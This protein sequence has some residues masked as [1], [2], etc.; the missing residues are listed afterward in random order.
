MAEPGKEP[1]KE[2]P[3]NVD[4]QQL[5]AYRSQRDTA[6]RRVHALETIC[7]HH[8]I[9]VSSVTPEALAKLP[10]NKG[11]VDG[12]FEYSPP[13]PKPKDPP[14]KPTEPGKGRKDGELTKEDVKKMSHKEI[15]DN[16]D[17]VKVVLAANK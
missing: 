1:G 12:A 4:A 11:V 8:S 16:W 6:I 17:K 7:K 3:P 10:I 2:Q 5:A 15:N 9:D 14:P 13:P